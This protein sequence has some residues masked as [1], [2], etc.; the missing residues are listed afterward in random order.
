MPPARP[1]LPRCP[2]ASL[3]YR[4]QATRCDSTHA[5]YAAI[6]AP[7]K[8][9]KRATSQRR[10]RGF[11]PP[12]CQFGPGHGAG[13]SDHGVLRFHSFFHTCTRNLGKLTTWFIMTMSVGSS[14][15]TDMKVSCA[16]ADA[17]ATSLR[18]CA[19]TSLR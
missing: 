18:I 4:H 5:N 19:L 12:L 13:H 2:D 14:D 7:A 10:Q 3:G 1:E 6:R 15:A 9:T 8:K 11:D 17:N 16:M